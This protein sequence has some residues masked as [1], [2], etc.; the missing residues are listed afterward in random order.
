MHSPYMESMHETG[1]QSCLYSYIGRKMVVQ[2]A[3]G[4]VTGR[5]KHVQPDHVVIQSGGAPFFI[6]TQQIIWAVPVSKSK[7]HRMY[8]FPC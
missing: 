1:F 8:P 2:T 5:L 4:S 7:K 3:R 6:R